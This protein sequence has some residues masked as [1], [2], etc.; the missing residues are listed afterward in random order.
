MAAT[1]T[2]L[3]ACTGAQADKVKL[4]VDVGTPVLLAGHSQTAYLKV[5]LTGFPIGAH[6]KRTPINV[7]IVLDRSGSMSGEKIRKAKEA[8]LM[9]VDQL[10]PED[11]V[12]VVS[13]NH[14]VDV[15]VPATKVRNRGQIHRRIDKLFA[16]GN[17]ALFAGVSKGAYE[18]RKFLDRN[19]I[20]RV[21]LLS[22]GLANVGPSSSSELASLGWSMAKE[23]ISVTTIGLGHDYN[24]DLMFSLA[25]NSDGNHAY[26]ANATD[27][28]RIFSYEFGDLLSVVAREVHVTIRC[29]PGI[30]PVLVLGRHAE[31]N[32]DTVVAR[33][34]QIYA[35]QEKFLLLEVQIPASPRGSTRELA[36]V[37]ISYANPVSNT[38]DMLGATALVRFSESMAAVDANRN[39]SVMVASVELI[40]NYA[41]KQAL[42]LRDQ[43]RVAEAERA[44]EDNA[45]YLDSA[46]KK[47]KSKKLKKRAGANRDDKANLAPARWK[48]QRKIMRDNQYEADMQQAW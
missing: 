14:T 39:E 32:G 42:D 26:A 3:L 47:Y 6:E 2:L 27:L 41:N 9:A 7:A 17:T 37:D 1:A 15:L 8:A 43:G 31:I 10:G 25:R 45:V 34:N 44:L 4:E 23:G 28:A 19:R 24:E 18:V 29:A 36:T 48:K 13:Y 21:I 38:T 22:D 5:G 33:L 11:I 20:N 16:S 40:A 35:E 12:S 30:R 46:A